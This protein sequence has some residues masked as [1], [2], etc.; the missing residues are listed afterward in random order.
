MMENNTNIEQI[1]L[2]GQPLEIETLDSTQ[3]KLND[4][5]I[6]PKKKNK[7]SKLLIIIGILMAMLIGLGVHYI[8]TINNP[9][10]IFTKA[11]DKFFGSIQNLIAETPNF[12]NESYLYEGNIKINTNVE[13]YAFLNNESFNYSMGIDLKNRKVETGYEIV[14]GNNKLIDVK[15][16]IKDNNAYIDFAD[17]FDKVI[18]LDDKTIKEN[19]GIGINDIFSKLEEFYAEENIKDIKYIV[20]SFNNFTNDALKK[21][22]YEKENSKITING[23]SVNVTKMTLAFTKENMSIIGNVFL[24]GILNDNKLIDELVQLSGSDKK[25]FID[26]L[27]EELKQIEKEEPTTISKISV[28]TTGILGKVVKLSMEEDNKE[29]I[30]FVNYKDYKLIVTEENVIEIND[31]KLIVKTGDDV[32]LT[33]KVNSF[34]EE[35]I[36]IDIVSE[37]KD[38]FKGN[39]A[40][41]N[42]NSSI[43]IDFNFEFDTEEKVILKLSSKTSK[44]SEK[45]SETKLTFGIEYDNQ[46]LE[47]TNTNKIT[48]G[49]NIANINTSKTINFNDMT[50]ADIDNI[51]KK[52]EEKLEK[53]EFGLLI[54][55]KKTPDY[56]ISDANHALEASKRAM[57]TISTNSTPIGYTKEN[58]TT[59]CFT[60]Q[61]LENAGYISGYDGYEGTIT[62]TQ[63]G[64][65]YSYRIEMYDDDYYVRTKNA[66]NEDVV[67]TTKYMPSILKTKCLD[68]AN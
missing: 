56:F 20:D 36:N 68:S 59:Y 23:K 31:K 57:M 47:M 16:N 4:N 33:G 8:Y 39:F 46:K 34:S 54:Y 11:S 24:N 50:E 67:Y 53:S 42:N 1:D 12:I 43:S 41:S 28:Y 58:D 26:G 6:I 35:N 3:T 21:V 17:L 49:A 38:L 55:F 14:E 5:P 37:E 10:T 18:L 45:V 22:T 13:D 48:T 40:Y 51:N 2:G 63:I 65:D 19:M 7:N 32:I 64:N 66:V 60:L 61:N 9:K 25:E 15:A 52:L 62:I 29:E 44:I 30:Y 27:K